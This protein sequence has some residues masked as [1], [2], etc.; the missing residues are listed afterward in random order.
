METTFTEGTC[1]KCGGRLQV[2]ADMQ[3]VICMYCGERFDV[4]RLII[5]G[6]REAEDIRRADAAELVERRMPKL[7]DDHHHLMD[8]FTRHTYKT[9]FDEYKGRQKD[10]IDAVDYLSSQQEDP[11]KYISQQ[12]SRFLVG[13]VRE[14]N[15]EKQGKGRADA[16]LVMHH[17]VMMLTVYVVPM[18]VDLHMETADK[19]ADEIIRQWKAL[20]PKYP[21][22]KGKF[23]IFNKSFRKTVLCFI[24]SAVCRSLGR[25]DDCEE[26]RTF[27]DFRDSYMM[28][29]PERMQDVRHYYEIA[30]AI[31]EAIDAREDAT[32][33]YQRI[34]KEDLSPCFVAIK[35]GRYE[36]A[37]RLYR[38][39]TE[40]LERIFVTARF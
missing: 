38:E 27:R 26:L 18:L 22:K 14:I 30:P 29:T 19:M 40:R 39:M 37:H 9:A 10:L 1:P 32:Q 13:L 33:I 28:Q 16:Q 20:F 3:Q 12:V 15:E 25:P 8:L 31:V 11:D 23:E 34:W 36:Q 7:A 35:T 21:F 24:T 17:Y 5:A 4:S 6:S 2:P